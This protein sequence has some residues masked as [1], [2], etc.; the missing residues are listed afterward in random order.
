M[1]K[2]RCFLY[3]VA[4][5]FILSSMYSSIFCSPASFH[6]WLKTQRSLSYELDY[7]PFAARSENSCLLYQI[8]ISS[9]P[10]GYIRCVLTCLCNITQLCFGLGSACKHHNRAPGKTWAIK[11]QQSAIPGH[12]NVV[13][14]GIAAAELSHRHTGRSAEI[15]LPTLLTLL[16]F[17][18]ARVVQRICAVCC[19]YR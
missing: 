7:L 13:T 15:V 9:L 16:D 3:M 19:S 18:W 14:Q 5:D 12:R 8:L 11:V 1:I 4:N 6:C 2:S 10:D 17:C